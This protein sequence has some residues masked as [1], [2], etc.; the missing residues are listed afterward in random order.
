MK[1][2]K[3]TLKVSVLS[4][5]L[6][7]GILLPIST[8]AQ[9]DPRLQHGG[10]FGLANSFKTEGLFRSGE[11]LEIDVEDFPTEDFEAP[12][13]SGIA[14]LVSVSLGYVALKK[15]KEDEQ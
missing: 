13:G 5:M 1:N 8:S 15:K 12:I 6:A 4:L 9:E 14:F 7:A 2:K 10:L 3:R 11:D